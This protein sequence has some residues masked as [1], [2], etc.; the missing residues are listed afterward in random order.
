MTIEIPYSNNESLKAERREIP[1]VVYL[2]FPARYALMLSTIDDKFADLKSNAEAEPKK[3]ELCFVMKNNAAWKVY[4]KIE[5]VEVIEKIKNL[6]PASVHGIF[7]QKS[8]SELNL[9]K[10]EEIIYFLKSILDE[11]ILQELDYALESLLAHE[12]GVEP[13]NFN[14]KM[15][16]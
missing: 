4:P 16:I 14:V 13:N 6:L 5:N 1:E 11:N 3:D 2:N 10:R 12:G 8:V 15:E 9:M 7:S